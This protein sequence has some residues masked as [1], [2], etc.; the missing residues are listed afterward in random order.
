MTAP[1]QGE[2]PFIPAR[3]NRFELLL[4]PCIGRPIE[5][6]EKSV[7]ILLQYYAIYGEIRG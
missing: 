7:A 3:L 4:L 1:N 6:L 5:V 2:L